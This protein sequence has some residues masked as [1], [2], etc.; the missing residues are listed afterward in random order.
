[1]KLDYKKF[2]AR[3]HGS[4]YFNSVKAFSDATGIKYS[5]IDR[6]L[7]RADYGGRGKEYEEVSTLDLSRISRVLGCPM[8]DLLHD[9]DK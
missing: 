4:E 3:F 8:Q 5:R 1:M 9:A 7:Y 2:R 6:W